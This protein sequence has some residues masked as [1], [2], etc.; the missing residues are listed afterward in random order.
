MW[1]NLS[2]SSRSLSSSFVDVIHAA[3]LHVLGVGISPLNNKSSFLKIV[4]T[5]FFF[6]ENRGRDTKFLIEQVTA[7][8]PIYAAILNFSITKYGDD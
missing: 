6:S 3:I 1:E 5:L 2:V 7:H 4:S 8:N